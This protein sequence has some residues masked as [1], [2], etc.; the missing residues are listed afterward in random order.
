MTRTNDTT[1]DAAS[2]GTLLDAHTIRF[3]R[4]LP[5]PIERV[6]DYLTDSDRRATWLGAGEVPREIGGEYVVRWEGEDGAP[7]GELRIRTR[8]Y[9]P[10]HVLEYDW[11]EPNA[12]G[13]AIRDSTVRF[14]LAERGDRVHLTLTHRALPAEAYTTI[15]A[16]WHAHLDT[17]V[18]QLAGTGGPDADARYAAIAPRYGVLG[19]FPER[20]VVRLERTLAAPVER[21]WSYLTEPELLATWLARGTLP[22]AIGEWFSLTLLANDDAIRATLRACDPPNIL[23]YTWFST[24]HEAPRAEHSIVHFALAPHDDGTRLVLTHAGLRPEFAG[25]VGAGWHALLDALGARVLGIDP[26]A[27]F[28]VFP[29][30]IDAYEHLV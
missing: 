10:S 16:G 1:P 15:G 9:D 20:G 17:L 2:Y 22:A 24:A 21:V 27:F 18:A 29:R 30:V 23:A 6:W 3:E 13:G 7:G 12:A 25:R 4:D 26:P 5:G 8:V 11:V 14:E 28:A 19:T